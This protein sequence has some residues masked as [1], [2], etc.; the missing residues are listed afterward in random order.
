MRFAFVGMIALLG[1]HAGT[2]RA[3]IVS[4]TDRPTWQTAAGPLSGTEDFNGFTADAQFRTTTVAANNMTIAG[5][6]GFNG[7]DTNLIDAAPFVFGG[8]YVFPDNSSYLLGDLVDGATIT[9][10][11]T[12]PL[13]A[14]GADFTGI[15]DGRPTRLDVFDTSS[16]LIGSIALASDDLAELQFYGFTTTGGDT[17]GS[18]VLV[19][20]GGANDVFG[21]DNIG[22]VAVGATAVPEPSS[23]ALAGLAG[24]AGLVGLAAR[25]RKARAT[26]E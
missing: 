14:W 5:S 1:L 17:V 11:F 23:L 13:T 8:F 2:A 24:L 21:I 19:N 6:T 20:P 25:G 22:F 12:R 15:A 7:D 18:I 16:V 3:G 9:F 26:A 4:Y 10:T